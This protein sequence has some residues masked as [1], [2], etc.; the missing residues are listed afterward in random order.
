MEQIKC[1]KKV[2]KKNKEYFS[3]VKEGKIEFSINP[4]MAFTSTDSTA[5]ETIRQLLEASDKRNSYEIS[6]VKFT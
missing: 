3:G 5:I 1:V 2:N 6:E 4:M